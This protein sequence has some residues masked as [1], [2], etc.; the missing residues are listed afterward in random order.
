MNKNMILSLC[1]TFLLISALPANGKE[2]ALWKDLFVQVGDVKIHYLEAGSG[3]RTL[4]LIP[5]WTMTAEIWKEQIAY[6][7]ARGFRVLAID[8]RS[9][10]L[11]AKTEKGN[12]YHQQAADLHALLQSLKVE[13]SYLVGWASGATSLL[14]YI[15]SP[16]ALTP[17]KMVFVDCSLADLKSDDY[18]AITTIER[19]R[20]QLLGF[21]DNRSKATEQYVRSLFK[22]RQSEMII[23]ELT[24]S[25]MKTPMGAA[26]MLYF[27]QLTGDRRPAL[28]HVPVPSLIMATAEN[29]VIAEYMKAKTPRSTLTVIDDA[30]SAMFMEKPQAFNQ[31][32]ESYFGER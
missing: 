29:R 6:F 16:E 25:S 32:L 21:E 14:E 30:G 4:V 10:G 3:D 11:S 19:A 20:K 23:S 8:P 28:A 31:A 17:E 27:D 18:P 5:G 15:S 2:N 26:S 22:S 24:K 1:L 9:Q 13:R 7:S 12:T